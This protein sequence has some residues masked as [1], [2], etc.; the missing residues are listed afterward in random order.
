MTFFQLTCTFNITCITTATNINRIE[1]H[2]II[3]TLIINKVFAKEKRL[4]FLY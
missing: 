4:R 1:I 2:R 3:K